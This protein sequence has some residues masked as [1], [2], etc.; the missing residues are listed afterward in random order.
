MLLTKGIEQLFLD[1][2]PPPD[3]TARLICY[4]GCEE[5]KAVIKQYMNLLTSEV[6]KLHTKVVVV[7][8]HEEL[9]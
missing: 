9:L 8:V 1:K 2:A 3:S 6:F 4:H 5:K 7:V